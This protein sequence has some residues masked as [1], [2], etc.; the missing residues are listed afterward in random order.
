MKRSQI[1]I[2]IGTV[3]SLLVLVLLLRRIDLHSFIVA[4]SGLDTTSLLFAVMITYEP[5]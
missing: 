4:V 2:G 3:F 5:Y 1:L